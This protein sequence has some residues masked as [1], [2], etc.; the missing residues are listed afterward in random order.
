MIK[1]ELLGPRK[2][3]PQVQ[4]LVHRLLKEMEVLV[5]SSLLS[6]E[7][8]AKVDDTEEDKEKKLLLRLCL[9]LK[10]AYQSSQ[11]GI[12]DTTKKSKSFEYQN[13]GL[14]PGAKKLVTRVSVLYCVYCVYF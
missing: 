5:N 12:V 10:S 13:G 2:F 8:N 3:S 7:M 6:N 9:L 1:P 11:I 4:V 14:W